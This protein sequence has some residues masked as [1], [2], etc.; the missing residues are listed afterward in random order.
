MLREFHRVTSDSVVVSLWVDGNYRAHIRAKQEGGRKNR[1][2]QNR[3]LQPRE[4]I[5]AEM[6]EAGFDIVGQVDFF[7][8]FSMWRIYVLHKR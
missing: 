7:K 1:R 4:K 5:E 6:G 2:Y 3:F 8:Y